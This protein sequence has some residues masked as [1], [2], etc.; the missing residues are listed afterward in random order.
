MLQLL[1]PI[2]SV[3]DA[4]MLAASHG[5]DV[6]CPFQDAL[7]AKFLP[8]SELRPAIEPRDDGFEISAMRI[9]MVPGVL[10]PVLVRF[11]LHVTPS[12]ELTVRE[13][14]E[15]PTTISGF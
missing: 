15:Y 9:D 5:Y 12:G 13:R 4:L 11:S 3:D 10:F 1:A 7:L 2:D 6:Q 14:R 8:A